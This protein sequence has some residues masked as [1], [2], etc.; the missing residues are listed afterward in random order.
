MG[1]TATKSASSWPRG[2]PRSPPS[3][4][5]CPSTAASAGCPG[6]A[7]S[8]VATLAGRQRRLL[9]PAGTRQPRRRLRACSTRRPRPAARRGR[10]RPPVRPGRSAAD[11]PPPARPAAAG[12]SH[13]SAPMLQWILDAMTAARRSSATAAWTSWP[14]TRSA[15]PSTRPLR[16]APADHA[17]LR[18]VPLPRPRAP[19]TSTPTGTTRRHHG[20]PAAHRSRPRPPRPGLTDLVGELSTR[21]DEFRTRWASTTCACT[22]PAPS[23]S[24]T[25]SSATSTSPSRPC[26]CPP[27]R[28]RPDRLQ[29]RTRHARSRRP[30]PA[31]QLGRDPTRGHRCAGRHVALSARRTAGHG[32]TVDG[33]P[34]TAMP[35]V[36][37]VAPGRCRSGSARIR[38][39]TPT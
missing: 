14:P 17:E 27:T 26:R 25:R 35:G 21:S 31:R 23:A 6:C 36:A 24:T 5:G 2:G 11:S 4:P 34:A 28:A 32:G 8:E 13:A 37:R 7:A 19:T 22:A 10:T 3:R 33:E 38:P 12:A 18:P 29:R 39:R 20:R 16:R 1:T 9:H 30:E 15:A